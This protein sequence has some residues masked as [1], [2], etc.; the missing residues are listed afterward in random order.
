MTGY[1]RGYMYAPEPKEDKPKEGRTGCFTGL[2]LVLFGLTVA[3]VGFA[4]LWAC[5]YILLQVY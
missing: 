4:I 2:T 1:K 5:A 3:S